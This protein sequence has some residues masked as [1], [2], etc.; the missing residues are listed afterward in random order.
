MVSW[1]DSIDTASE[2]AATSQKLIL[3][4]FFSPT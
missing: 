4:D 1:L 2:R 3:V